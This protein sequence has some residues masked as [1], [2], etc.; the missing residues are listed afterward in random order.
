[1]PCQSC[2]LPNLQVTRLSQRQESFQLSSQQLKMLSSA[3]FVTAIFLLTPFSIA[4]PTPS[5]PLSAYQ[6]PTT[7]NLTALG[8]RDGLSTIECWQLA[9]PFQT[10]NQ[11]GVPGTS[12]LPLGNI[13]DMSY[14]VIPPKYFPDIH[15]APIIQYVVLFLKFSSLPS[16]KPLKYPF[17]SPDYNDLRETQPNTYPFPF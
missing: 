8:A 11:V 1:M 10:T 9:N 16:P 12:Q 4:A 15:P 7:L 6:G 3:L 2:P 17:S 14:T 13:T 5:S